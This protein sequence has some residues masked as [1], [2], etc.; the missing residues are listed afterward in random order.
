LSI[1]YTDRLAEAE[2]E[3][4]V[5]SRGDSYDNALAESV[6]GLYKTEVI[7]RKGPWRGFDDVEYATLEWVD[8]YNTQR[9][10]GPIGLIPPAEHET[11]YYREDQPQP[12]AA[13][14]N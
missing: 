3:R 9:L 12:I 11:N 4:S 6:I 8:W 10:F 2:I 13:G 14:L 7:R 1:R 5:G